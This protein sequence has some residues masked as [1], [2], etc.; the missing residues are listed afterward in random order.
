MLAVAEDAELGERFAANFAELWDGRE[1]ERS[2]YVEPEPLEVG[3]V[4]GEGL[5]HAR[6]RRGA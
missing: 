4:P 5:V 2:G 6:P 1:V 3:G